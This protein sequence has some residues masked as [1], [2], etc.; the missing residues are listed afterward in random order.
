M[1]IEINLLTVF[2][3]L[4]GMSK[5]LNWKFEYWQL[6]D[7]TQRFEL[8]APGTG[9]HPLTENRWFQKKFRKEELYWAYLYYLVS[10]EADLHG[11]NFLHN[12]EALV[13]S[14]GLIF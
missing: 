7:S 11:Q 3:P 10:I 9:Y 1:S 8:L 2:M 6:L 5:I 12:V 4:L 14:K 13:V